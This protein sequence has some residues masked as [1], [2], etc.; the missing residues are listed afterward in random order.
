ITLIGFGGMGKSSLAKAIINE[1][2]AIEKFADR[3]FFV[4]YDGLDPSTIT[5]ETFTTRFAETLGIEL[6]GAN[7][8][9]QISTFLR[10]ATALIV[11]DNAETFE[12]ASGS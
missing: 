1:P 3:C 11:L 8:M 10:S 7:P 5:F 9:R 12:E 4:T 6:A 2:P